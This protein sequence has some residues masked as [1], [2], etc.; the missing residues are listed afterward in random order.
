MSTSPPTLY[1]NPVAFPKKYPHTREAEEFAKG[2]YPSGPAGT[3]VILTPTGVL[4]PVWPLKPPPPTLTLSHPLL[5]ERR[6]DR[7]RPLPRLPPL[8]LC[9]VRFL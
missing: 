7:R 1:G 3:P 4:P 6:I 5:R 2:K 8:W 9:R